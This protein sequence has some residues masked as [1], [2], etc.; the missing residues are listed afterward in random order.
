[1]AADVLYGHMNAALKNMKRNRKAV[2]SMT[3]PAK[4][5]SG[6]TDGLGFGTQG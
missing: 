6:L 1:M 4:E 3:N 2:I 5:M